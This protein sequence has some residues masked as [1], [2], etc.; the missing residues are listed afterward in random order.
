MSMTNQKNQGSKNNKPI[1]FTKFK[2]Y[3][4]IFAYDFFKLYFFK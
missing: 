3:V 4:I 2:K 1:L